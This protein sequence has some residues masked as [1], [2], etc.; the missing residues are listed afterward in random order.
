MKNFAIAINIRPEIYLKDPASTDLGKKI[1]SQSIY[2]ID[3][4]GFE[5]FNFKKLAQ[6]I[7]ST[8]SSVYRYFENKHYLFIYL[9]NWYW[10]WTSNRMEIALI[11]IEDP[12][13]KIKQVIKTVIRTSFINTATPFIDEEVLHR[14]MIREGGKAYHHKSVDNENEEGFFLSYKDL[15][16]KISQVFKEYNPDYTYPKSLASTFIDACNSNIYF[17][18]HL[19]RLTE[20][21][22]DGDQNKMKNELFDMMYDLIMNNLNANKK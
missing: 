11:N 20:I 15:C 5:D 10:E 19:P 17:A 16:E 13:L 1:L 12:D 3:S 18:K 6:K 21:T 14:I 8:E 2:L 4:L 7:A 22:F 9:S